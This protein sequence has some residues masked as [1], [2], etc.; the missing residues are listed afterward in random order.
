MEGNYSP[1]AA[2]ELLA[3]ATQT[4]ANWRSRGRGPRF[5]KTPDGRVVYSAADLAAFMA[6]RGTN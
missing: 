2:A 3:V 1:K 4:L 5:T 6:S